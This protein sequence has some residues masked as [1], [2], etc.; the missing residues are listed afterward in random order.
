MS[1]AWITCP[2]TGRRWPSMKR[3]ELKTCTHCAALIDI[4]HEEWLDGP[5]HCPG[6]CPAPSPPAVS[7]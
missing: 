6:N 1:D 2:D 7:S 3:T 4:R 5:S